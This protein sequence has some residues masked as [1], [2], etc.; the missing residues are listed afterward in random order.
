MS[1]TPLRSLV[2][3]VSKVPPSFARRDQSLRLCAHCE[4]L[5]RTSNSDQRCCS[6]ACADRM[7]EP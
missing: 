5:F 2:V 6:F 4:R 1:G 7:G 3:L